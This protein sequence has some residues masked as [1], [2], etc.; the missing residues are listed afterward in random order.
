MQ[1]YLMLLNCMCT[2]KITVVVG[3]VGKVSHKETLEEDENA[4][5]FSR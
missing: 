4:L 5:P 1:M 3:G 2:Y